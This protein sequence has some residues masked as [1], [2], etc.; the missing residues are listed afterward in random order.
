MAPD[1]KA[2]C[3]GPEYR[4][5]LSVA[6]TIRSAGHQAYFAGGCVRD[7]LLGRIPKDFDVATSA[8]PD[9][10][11][12]LFPKTKSVGAHFGVVL[13]NAEAGEDALDIEIATFR[14]DGIYTDGRRPDAVR[15][16]TDPK[17]DV[18]RRD[19][20]INGML[21]DPISFDE[22]G[23]LDASVLDFVGGRA[24]LN[25]K[26]VRAIGDPATRFAED[27]LRM[28]RA[29]RFA[30]RLEFEIDPP[31]LAAIRA[32]AASI[33]KVSIERIAAELTMMLTEGHARRAFELLDECGLLAYVL[34]EATK[35]K[36]VEQP[37]QYHPEG[38]VWVH[39]LLLL[40]KLPAGVSPT[41]AWGALLHD[42]G[43]P[44]TFTAPKPG[45]AGDRIRFNGHVEVGVRMAEVILHRLRFSNEDAEQIVALVKNH[46]RFGDI[47]NM[48]Q[49]TLKR[50]LRMPKF[51]EHLELH[52][53]DVLSS[54]GNL[55]LYEFAKQHFHD[56]P[57]E[58]ARPK[59]FVSGRDL[60]VAGYRPG[61]QFKEMLE[62]AEDA[63]LDG[64]VSTR[65]EALAILKE[66][67][68]APP[69][70]FTTLTSA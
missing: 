67:F 47:L 36:G 63:Q 11:M 20:T 27:K 69:Q 35:L 34:P 1:P 13:A 7:L 6:G 57:E 59:P 42:I 45:V 65:A 19:F 58:A 37:P 52:R 64:L 62:F 70:A 51:E 53:M 56:D 31:T 54:N 66:R 21:L 22:T 29:V 68:G 18:V 17:E 46:M 2:F 43:K 3:R 10:V 32:Q 28:L 39:T 41:L 15:F 48:R 60:I 9:E 25:A 16:S 55:E 40:E 26:T 24:D 38:D 5:A 12:A 49:A 23:D 4:A 44:A 30:A 50:F 61:V 8:T 33:S 14:N